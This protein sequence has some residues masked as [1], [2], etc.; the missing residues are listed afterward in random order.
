[1]ISCTS[2]ES[3]RAILFFGIVDAREVLTKARHAI[4]WA[5]QG[6]EKWYGEN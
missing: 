4:C 2:R 5:C 1:M 3:P 6:S